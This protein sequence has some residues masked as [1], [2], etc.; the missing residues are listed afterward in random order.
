MCYRICDGD[1]VLPMASILPAGYGQ[2][3]HP[4]I[5]RNTGPDMKYHDGGKG[6]FKLKLRLQ[7]T[8]Y[9]NVSAYVFY[10]QYRVIIYLYIQYIVSV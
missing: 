8:V 6:I 5:S 4:G 2:H 7:S 9:T 1:Q 3:D 10:I